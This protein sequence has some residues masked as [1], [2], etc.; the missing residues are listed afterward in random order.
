MI[1]TSEKVQKDLRILRDGL[2]GL[3]MRVT[4]DELSL[5]LFDEIF[6]SL[7]EYLIELWG[8]M[9]GHTVKSV[10]RNYLPEGRKR[11]VKLARIEDLG[12]EVLIDVTW[13]G[14]YFKV[15]DVEFIN[16]DTDEMVEVG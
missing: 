3:K 7:T 5:V 16:P 12:L 10:R 4:A 9:R 2:R 14:R 8:K 11:K 13:T 1:V 15:L 6:V